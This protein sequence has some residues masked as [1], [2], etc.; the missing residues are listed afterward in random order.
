MK[1]L[2]QRTL[3]KVLGYDTYLWYF[4]LYK[5]RTLRFD[6]NEND[7]FHFLSLIKPNQTTLDIGANLGLMSYHLAKNS[8]STYAFEPMPNNYA[9][10]EKVKSKYR[11]DNLHILTNALGNEN[12]S[13]SLVL[14]EVDGVKKQGLSHVV[15]NKM[16][17]FN[18]GSIFETDCYRLDDQS[19]LK[20]VK[21]DAI[22]IDV[23]NF[24]Y[25]VFLGA[26]NILKSY[27]PI[28]YCELWDNQNRQDCFK[29]L[30][31]LGYETKVLRRGKLEVI[32]SN[33][34]DIQNFFFIPK[35][36]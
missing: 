15:D 24:E 28:I 31:S 20:G 12:K 35:Q 22:K 34:T 19:E 4:T 32:Q 17:E 36:T 18:D 7:F 10:V 26:E 6:K 33:P 29:Y 30:E 3:Q 14:P 27:R 2:I 25:E 23:E 11:L 8:K 13:I 1:A 9:V 16:T 5:L 21:I